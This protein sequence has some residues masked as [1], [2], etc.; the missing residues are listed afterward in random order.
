ML[1]KRG[2]ESSEDVWFTSFLNSSANHWPLSGIYRINCRHIILVTMFNGRGI[3]N[4]VFVSFS[5]FKLSSCTSLGYIMSHI[6]NIM[7]ID[8]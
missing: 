2:S 3:M 6:S 7:R 4:D 8:V 1:V 5:C